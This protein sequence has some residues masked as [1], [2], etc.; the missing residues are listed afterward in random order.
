MA[1]KFTL[2]LSG[3]S[4]AI[5][6]AGDGFVVTK[7]ACGHWCQHWN[8]IGAILTETS[9]GIKTEIGGTFLIQE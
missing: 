9:I 1:K 8:I 6:K 3:K 4:F 5:T 2:T 7:N